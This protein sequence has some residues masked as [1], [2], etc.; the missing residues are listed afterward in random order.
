MV[1]RQ[2]Q[3]MITLELEYKFTQSEQL[4]FTAGRRLI[5]GWRRGHV[6]NEN[7]TISLRRMF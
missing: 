7:F 2:D 6:R 5:E 3:R 4:S 1:D